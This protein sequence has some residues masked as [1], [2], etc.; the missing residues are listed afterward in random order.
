MSQTMNA[1]CASCKAHSLK[2]EREWSVPSGKY[3]IRFY[4]Q[5]EEC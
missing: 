2:T 4:D 5:D 3:E 1:S